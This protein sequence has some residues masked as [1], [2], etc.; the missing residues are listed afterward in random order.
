MSFKV[1][2]VVRLKSGGPPMTVVLPEK[3]V[4]TQ[5]GGILGGIWCQWFSPKHGKAHN[6]NFHP[7]TLVLADPDQ[8]VQ[9]P[10]PGGGRE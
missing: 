3:P 1:G 2:D 7:E 5:T 10:I 8:R 6:N 9:R 4:Q